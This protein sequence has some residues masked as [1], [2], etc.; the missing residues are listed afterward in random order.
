MLNNICGLNRTEYYGNQISIIQSSGYGKSRM[1]HEQAKL[2]FTIPFNLR[3][4]RDDAGVQFPS[5]I[6]PKRP[7]F[8]LDLAFPPADC[9][10]RNCL[11]HAHVLDLNGVTKRYLKFFA[12]LFKGTRD[13]LRRHETKISDSCALADWWSTN[14]N[15]IRKSLYSHVAED[16]KTEMIIQ[17]S[18]K[19]YHENS[20]I[21][22]AGKRP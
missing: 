11:T 9:D 14:V 2:V 6:R 3:P 18:V 5:P 10:I 16:T 4:A 19:V 7:K 13:E 8:A 20:L 12:S 15:A 22:L 21:V 1:V 17:V